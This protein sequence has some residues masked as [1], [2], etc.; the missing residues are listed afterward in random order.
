[1][2]TIAVAI[3]TDYLYTYKGDGLD[4]ITAT[5]IPS[6]VFDSNLTYKTVH[7][8]AATFVSTALAGAT[9]LLVSQTEGFGMRDETGATVV[10][11]DPTTLKGFAVVGNDTLRE[12][13][14]K[15]IN[16][17]STTVPSI[18][19]KSNDTRYRYY[20]CGQFSPQMNSNGSTKL[21]PACGHKVSAGGATAF[22]LWHTL[23]PVIPPT[24]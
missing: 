5:K 1:M 21:M 13:I 7:D 17:L 20:R 4:T 8:Q 23:D 10:P 3:G 11:A 19:I 24:P 16:K 22:S 12:L 15:H 9:K 18:I 14:I 2:T 6:V